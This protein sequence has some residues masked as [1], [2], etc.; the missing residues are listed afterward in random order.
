M[1]ISDD[2]LEKALHFMATTD[3]EAAE[4]KA[5]VERAEYRCK[6]ARAREFMSA[7]GSVEARKASAESS[8]SV[9]EV[10]DTRYAAILAYEKIKAKRATEE[11]IVEVW[12]TCSANSRRANV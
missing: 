12:R 10:E 5:E 4:L 8:Q 6:L 7:E 3:Q 9:Q 1:R 11:L 2:R